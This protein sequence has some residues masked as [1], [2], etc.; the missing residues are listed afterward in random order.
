MGRLRGQ[1]GKGNKCEIRKTSTYNL[2][3][4]WNLQTKTKPK[5]RYREQIIG[6]QKWG[7]EWRGSEVGKISEGSK[8]GTN[9]HL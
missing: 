8:K 7:E 3:Y 4:M 2:T 6:C 5:L 1:Y 9:F